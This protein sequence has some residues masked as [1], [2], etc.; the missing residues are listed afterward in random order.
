M[1]RHITFLWFLEPEIQ[2]C[3]TEPK[4]R[5]SQGY[6]SSGS[7]GEQ[8]IFW[9]FPACGG[10]SFGFWS[11]PPS[12]KLV[13][14]HLLWLHFPLLPSQDFFPMSGLLFHFH[15]MNEISFSFM[16]AFHLE[17]TQIIQLSPSS[18][19]VN[20]F[21]LIRSTKSSFIMKVKVAQSCLT[22]CDPMDCRVHG[23]LQARIL[24]W[25]AFPF[26]RRSSQPRD[27]AQVSLIVGGFFTSWATREA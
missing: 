18:N 22:L 17:S 9:S 7:S 26:S 21:N 1:I 27:W 24:E 14:W 6:A 16:V 8:C 4:P 11:L 2:K 15:E 25:I 3:V 20:G 12:S 5:F 13:V 19:C 10:A 23:I